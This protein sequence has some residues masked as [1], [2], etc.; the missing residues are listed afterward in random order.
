[1]R[2]LYVIAF[3]FLGFVL[4]GCYEF[5]GYTPPV[6]PMGDA[7]PGPV[8]D[9]GW[10]MPEPDSGPTE[11]D[12]GSVVTADAGMPGSDAGPPPEPD[13]GTMP[14]P[15]AGP[16]VCMG[17]PNYALN[18]GSAPLSSSVAA[19]A[20][21]VPSVGITLTTPIDSG[22]TYTAF[23]ILGRGDTDGTFRTEHFRDVVTSCSIF[24]GETRLG[25]GAP[26]ERG[27][28]LV[29]GFSNHLDLGRSANLRVE[30]DTDTDVAQLSGDRYVVALNGLIRGAEPV[31]ATDDLGCERLAVWGRNLLDQL[32]SDDPRVVVTVMNDPLI[33]AGAMPPSDIIVAGTDTWS[34]VASYEIV[35]RRIES[36]FVMI[37]GFAEDTSEVAIAHRDPATGFSSIIGRGVLPSGENSG[38]TIILDA[39]L[40]MGDAFEVWVKVP[41]ITTDPTLR[42]RSGDSF[43]MGVNGVGTGGGTF[44]V[45]PPLYG[46]EFVIRRSVPF[47][48]RQAL[49]PTEIRN[50]TDQDLYRFQVSADAAGPISFLQIEMQVL[51]HARAGYGEVCNMRLRRG[52]D[53]LPPDSYTIYALE[54]DRTGSGTVYESP[55][56]YGRAGS[57]VVIIRL[58]EEQTV[59]GSGNVYTLHGTV[60][61][62]SS[63]DWITTSFGEPGGVVRPDTTITTGYIIPNTHTW[64]IDTSPRGMPGTAPDWTRVRAGFLWSD[65]SDVPHRATVGTDGGSRDWTNGYLIEDLTQS[66]TLV[67]P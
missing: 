50:G 52:W 14:E 6:I 34:H 20:T 63:G 26:D 56:V 4:S 25:G 46:N 57:G 48:A 35:S 19:G 18:L 44:F 15:D 33:E 30:C 17:G 2:N 61:R 7:G 21:A 47:I 66:Q 65:L 55:C 59:S 43:R 5:H 3:A 42:P 53:D 32:E 28:I 8:G 45:T 37:D 41:F 51:V 39:P 11:P 67:M 10:P 49:S 22:L 36:V 23:A 12:A 60:N 38:R 27:L 62:F 64:A 24:D 40:E 29:G 9:A 13:S 16:H 31:T 58:S 1:M 54:V